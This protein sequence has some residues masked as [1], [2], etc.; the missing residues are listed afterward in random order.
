MSLVLI[1]FTVIPL[2]DHLIMYC[3]GRQPDPTQSQDN[4]MLFTLDEEEVWVRLNGPAYEE[5]I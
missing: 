2:S 3:V 4:D 1:W 5:V